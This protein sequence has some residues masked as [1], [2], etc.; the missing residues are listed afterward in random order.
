MKKL[1]LIILV[2]SITFVSFAGEND[3]SVSIEQLKAENEQ[4]KELLYERAY[5]NI[6]GQTVYVNG[7]IKGFTLAYT[8]YLQAKDKLENGGN[9]IV[10]AGEDIL[11]YNPTQ[12]DNFYL[13]LTLRDES[14]YE[15][16]PKT[17]YLKYVEKVEKKLTKLENNISNIKTVIPSYVFFIFLII[18]NII[19][20]I[21]LVSV[22]KTKVLITTRIDDMK[23]YFS[24]YLSLFD[25]V[26]SDEQLILEKIESSSQRYNNLFLVLS[27]K[28]DNGLA[29]II[30]RINVIYNTEKLKLPETN[31]ENNNSISS[32]KLNEN[33]FSVR[34]SNVLKNAHINTIPELLNYNE[35]N[36]KRL[37]G[38]SKKCFSEL[39]EWMNK[40]NIQL[41]NENFFEG[42]ST[43]T[44][45][46]LKNQGIYNVNSLLNTSL[47]QLRHN[48][49]F[50]KKSEKELTEWLEEKGLRLKDSIMK[51]HD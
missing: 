29:N 22:S 13:K 38:M 5:V 24:K 40:N 7:L 3:S 51:V 14:L 12:V 32:I 17:E 46:V 11:D 50:G 30:Q 25:R 47:E 31:L 8:K 27:S 34:L 16:D 26:S 15:P 19:L 36:I 37:P 44:V 28:F 4:L 45:N 10:L 48:R 2:F 43:R 49:N 41:S 21:Q 23:N 6:N 1:F 42:L 33:N 9:L 18:I 35:T 39:T 20:I